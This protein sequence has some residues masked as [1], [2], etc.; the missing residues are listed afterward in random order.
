M[1]RLNRI[2]NRFALPTQTADLFFLGF[3]L[4]DFEL[5]SVIGNYLYHR[6]FSYDTDT[7][8][9]RTLFNIAVEKPF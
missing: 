3:L 8:I 6:E 9:E 7:C 1:F 5:W 4:D 2:N